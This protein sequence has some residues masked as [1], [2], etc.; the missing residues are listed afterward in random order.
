MTTIHRIQPRHLNEHASLYG[1]QLLEWIDNYCFAKTEKYKKDAGEKF[2]TRA[3]NC[4][5]LS[6]IFLGDTIEIRMKNET[7][8]NT[9]ITF[10][11]EVIVKDKVVAKGSS[12]FVKLFND[13]PASIINNK[14]KIEG[15][16]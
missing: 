1:G 8:K 2:V 9:S 5:F 14:N 15:V 13:K 6:P 10:D 11:Y 3:T 7:I 16:N 4:E 12:T